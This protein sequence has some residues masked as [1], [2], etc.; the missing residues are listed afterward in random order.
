MLTILNDGQGFGWGGDETRFVFSLEEFNA[1]PHPKIILLDSVDKWYSYDRG[2]ADLTIYWVT[3]A[4]ANE[5]G[6]G[7]PIVKLHP[8]D[9]IFSSST[10][11]DN[12]CNLL[13]WFAYIKD[14]YLTRYK[15]LIPKN[16]IFANNLCCTLG[17]GRITR[18]YT[19]H[20][21][22]VNNLI[23]RNISFATH[24]FCHTPFPDACNE[25]PG[26]DNICRYLCN[27]DY[28]QLH[29]RS[30]ELDWRKTKKLSSW[31]EQHLPG[32]QSSSI[33]PTHAYLDS[34]LLF[35]HETIVHNP[36]FFVTEKTIK[37]LLS[38]RPC[39]IVGCHRFLEQLRDLG[40]LTWSSVLDESYDEQVDLMSRIDHAVDSAKDFITQNVLNDARK[41]EKIRKITEHNKEV[42]F[43]TDWTR[44][45]ISSKKQILLELG[46]Y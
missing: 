30:L 3:E 15:F 37:G 25:L 16:E 12:K 44:N 22:I 29:Y 13:Y 27:I 41:L 35:I 42:F 34:S 20:R 21:F 39:I 14:L 33:I 5:R 1:A 7:R 46:I 40:F 18:V 10:G 43:K 28:N 31:W 23:N 26:Q 36:E 2:N 4:L 11:P 38:G 17:Q 9:R 45:M 6:E 24:D 8:N 32:I 19:Y